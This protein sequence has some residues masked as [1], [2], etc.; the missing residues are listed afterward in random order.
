M[1]IGASGTKY[2]FHQ[3][4]GQVQHMALQAELI[5]VPNPTVSRFRYDLVAEKLA[6]FGVAMR[7][8]TVEYQI[9]TNV[10]SH[11][12]YCDGE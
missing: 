11:R 9:W 4:L 1:K 12:R 7:I 10:S 5:P 8:T 3:K 2:G 6:I